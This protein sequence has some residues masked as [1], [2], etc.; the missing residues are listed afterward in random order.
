MTRFAGVFPPIITPF[1]D[2]GE[3]DVP[4]LHGHIDF[5]IEAGVHG[6]IPAGSTGEAISLSL[7]EYHTLVRETISHTAGRVPVLAGCSANATQQ[8]VANCRFAEEA[9]ADGI[10]ITHPYYSLPDE[11]ELYQHYVTVAESVSLPIMIYNNP[12]TTG[13]DSSPELLGR[14][15]ECDTIQ[16]VKESSLDCTRIIRILEAA[17]DRLA[18][19]SGTDNQVLE[20]LIV[21]AT[22]WVSGAANVIPRQCVALYELGRDPHRIQDAVALY[23][24]LY[25]YLTLCEASGKFVQIAKAG[26]ERIGRRGGLPRPPL[27]P[28]SGVLKV[29]MEQAL[30][31]ALQAM[32]IAP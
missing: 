6:L 1:T 17:G 23:R 13:V 2:A 7:D 5:L 29:Q 8:V 11:A 16:Y 9:G 30:E 22:G 3:L 10:M 27:L 32:P 18:V 25:A 4:A 12:F 26:L 15:S 24:K 19:F 14:L 21:G 28:L 31:Q 20:H